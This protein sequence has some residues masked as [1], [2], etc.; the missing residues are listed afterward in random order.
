MIS[1][2]YKRKSVFLGFSKVS[3][4]SFPCAIVFFVV[5]SFSGCGFPV[6]VV[7]KYDASAEISVKDAQNR[8]VEN[9]SMVFTL[10][11]KDTLMT[12]MDDSQFTDS[13]GK[14]LLKQYYENLESRYHR[15]NPIEYSEM[16]EYYL[17]QEH[18]FYLVTKKDGYH[19]RLDSFV[20]VNGENTIVN[21]ILEKN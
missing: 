2:S 8:P 13:Q 6:E 10:Q 3:S 11:Y 14:Y 4:V 12:Y 16:E 1:V 17:I 21:V 19:E 9:A 5:L 20:L 18:K 7:I 15:E